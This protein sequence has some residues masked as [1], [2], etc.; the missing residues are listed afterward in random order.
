MPPKSTLFVIFDCCHSGSAIELP[1][2]YR[3]DDDGNMNM[4][5]NFKEAGKLLTSAAGLVRGGFSMS[6]LGQA[7]DLATGATNLFKSF[8]G[9]GDDDGP[10]GL[11]KQDDFG[12]DWSAE[13]KFCTSLS[14]LRA[15]I[16]SLI[17]RV[18]LLTMAFCARLV[19]SGCRDDQTSADAS[20]SGES[21]G[22]MSWAFLAT[23]AE[24]QNISYMDVSYTLHCLLTQR[25]KESEKKVLTAFPF[26]SNSGAHRDKK[27]TQGQPVHAGPPA[28][29]RIQGLG[30]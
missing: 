9:G 21:Q 14:F 8:S 18:H 13:N 3:T 4:M 15:E 26:L 12:Q 5:D 11:D 24:N 22:A 7:R 29:S 2:V 17:F 30:T 16:D 28:F 23:L 6:S 20:I 27:E 25:R 10:E 19:F 1:Y